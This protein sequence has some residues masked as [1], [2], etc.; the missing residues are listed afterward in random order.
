MS[1]RK[2][3]ATGVPPFSPLCVEF[4]ERLNIFTGDNG[5]GK[6]LLLDLAFWQLSNNWPGKHSL[7]SMDSQA[8]VTSSVS[9][10]GAGW[11]DQGHRFEAESQ[12]WKRFAI[13]R[14]PRTAL[15]IYAQSNGG[16]S[17]WDPARNYYRRP[18]EDD[19]VG[20]SPRTYSFSQEEVWRG[21]ESD[22]KSKWLCNGLIRDW[23]SWQNEQRPAFTV[24]K[25]VLSTLAPDGGDPFEPGTPIRLH[26]DDDQLHPTIRTAFGDIPI[27]LASEA[28]QRMCALAYL[29]VWTW[30]GHQ[31]A[32]VL[33]GW[34]PTQ[35]IVLL[36][37][38]L[39]AHLHPKWQRSILPALM[40]AIRDL[41]N[42]AKVQLIGVTHAPLLLS[43]VE[44][45]FDPSKDQLF[46]IEPHEGAAV[47]HPV[48]FLKRGDVDAWFLSEMFR[49]PSTLPIPAEEAVQEAKAWLNDPHRDLA[50]ATRLQGALASTLSEAD[51]FWPVWK[52]HLEQFHIPN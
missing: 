3:S 16:F 25:K 33:R 42:R 37:D 27:I 50:E 40:E 51:P 11:V 47:V 18:I 22:D 13:G 10:E 31:A 1:I 21:I 44:Q 39:E 7:W 41:S 32:A 43:S 26:P 14:P 23:V 24:L 20:E 49:L 48:P 35:R 45:V 36:F 4:A 8:N 15:L 9:S 52:Y 12:A 28:I 17:V 6:S 2:L 46:T 19:G 5:L 29:L 30:N 34:P 38:E